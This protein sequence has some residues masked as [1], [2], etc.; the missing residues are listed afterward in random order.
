[1]PTGA[2]AAITT[3]LSAWHAVLKTISATKMHF[4]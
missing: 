4:S 3:V 1:M 2:Q